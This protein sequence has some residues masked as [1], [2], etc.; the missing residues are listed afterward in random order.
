MWKTVS[1]NKMDPH[2]S[3]Y[4]LSRVQS[5]PKKE[6]LNHHPSSAVVHMAV[7]SAALIQYIRLNW[8]YE[9]KHT[10][11]ISNWTLPIASPSAMARYDRRGGCP[12][13]EDNV[14]RCWCVSHSLRVGY[15]RAA[16]QKR[17]TYY[18]DKSAWPSRDFVSFMYIH[19]KSTYRCHCIEHALRTS[20]AYIVLI[21]KNF[22][23]TVFQLCIGCISE[24]RGLRLLAYFSRQ[25]K[26]TNHDKEA[27]WL[28]FF[29]H[30][31]VSVKVCQL[32][33]RAAW[34]NVIWDARSKATIAV[35]N[36]ILFRSRRTTRTAFHPIFAWNVG[37]PWTNSTSQT[38]NSASLCGLWSNLQC[39]FLPW[40]LRIQFD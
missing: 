19:S 10:S 5:A 12:T 25:P 1:K 21:T 35:S 38:T 4:N 18:L 34:S 15:F 17:N 30:Q 6:T 39:V 24:L 14:S 32:T 26:M 40:F 16:L 11:V 29:L 27:C 8:I 22:T 9:T 33:Q 36:S 13:I 7:T 28:L 23:L 37:Q 3:N 20:S 2:C 31:G